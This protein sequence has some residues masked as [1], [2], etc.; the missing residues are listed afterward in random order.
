MS[1]RLVVSVLLLAWPA[2]SSGFTFRVPE[3]HASI[4][5]AID[6][7][8]PSAIDT[9]L[10]SPGTYNERIRIRFKHLVLR[11]T[12]APEM[13]TID[14]N[15]SG[16]VVT[17]NGVGRSCIIEDLTI[18]GGDANHPDSVG[19]AI[20]LNQYASPTIQRCRL[21]GNRA[22]S[23]GGI[24]AYVFCEP[25]VRDCWIADNSGGAVIFEL[26][27][28]DAGTTWAEVENTVIVNNQGFGVSVLKGARAWLR[29]CTLAYNAD[30]I[31]AAQQGRVRVNNTIVAFSTGS[32]ISRSDGSA[33]LTLTCNDVY[34]NTGGNYVGANPSD[35]CFSGR[36]NGDVTVDPCFQNPAGD[37]YH[38]EDTSPLCALR[39]P[40]SCGVLGAYADPCGPKPPGT[41]V[42]AVLPSDWSGVKSLYR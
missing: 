28:G 26:A 4:Q 13:T 33:C 1:R 34:G 37:N 6:L 10:L 14:G 8:S 20:Y 39:G 3:Q 22:R 5:A 15:L 17:V 41:C 38:L 23:G 36:G 35:P 18:T 24:A 42:V 21:V 32:G 31:G 40:G 25:L 27:N 9:V 7:A 2:V 29:N 12:G 19:A 30:A 11:G 16:N